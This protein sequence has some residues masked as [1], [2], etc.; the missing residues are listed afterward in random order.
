MPYPEVKAKADERSKSGIFSVPE[1]PLRNPSFIGVAMKRILLPVLILWAVSMTLPSLATA[2]S[3]KKGVDLFNEAKALNAKA[4]SKEDREKAL[5]KF[6]EALEIFKKDNSKKDQANTINWMASVY[7]A[8]GQ[9]Q[10]AVEVYRKELDIRKSLND[11]KAEGVVLN[12]IGWMFHNLN[13]EQ[14]A[15]ENL[16]KS[17]EM[18]RKA[19]NSPM[20]G[21]TLN[22]IG[23]VYYK[24][25]QYQKA[26]DVWA[27][28]LDVKKKLNDGPGQGLVLHNMATAYDNMSD[29]LKGVEYYEKSLELYKKANDTKGAGG[30]LS[31]IAYDYERLGDH[32]KCV[33]YGEKA[34]TIQ[35]MIKDVNGEAVA[36][37]RIGLGY[38]GL[39]QYSKA[40]ECYEKSLELHRKAG[41]SKSEGIVLDNMGRAYVALGDEQKAL[42]HYKNALEIW[43]R[44]HDVQWEAGTLTRMGFVYDKLGELQNALDQYERAM[45]IRKKSGDRLGEANLVYNMGASYF[46]AAQF[47]K[48]L[49]YFDKAL[50]IYGALG[51]PKGE[52]NT[53][54]YISLTCRELSQYQKAQEAGERALEIARRIENPDMQAT[55]LLRVGDTYLCTGRS[56]K[57]LEYYT[58]ALNLPG[59]KSNYVGGL[60]H[61]MGLAY[62]SRGEYQ[63]AL[64][65]YEKALADEVRVKNLREQGNTLNC[66]GAA[67]YQLGQYRKALESYEKGLA[68][69]RKTGH[70]RAEANSL[71]RIGSFYQSWGDRQKALEY[72]QNAGA[73]YR[74]IG[75]VSGEAGSFFDIGRVHSGLNEY[76]EAI[77]NYQ[78][79]MEMRE[80]IGIPTGASKTLMAAVYMEKRQLDKAEEL[81]KD[82]NFGDQD[83]SGAP[84]ANWALGKL[85]LLKGDFSESELY[86]TKLLNQ[87]EKRRNKPLRVTGYTGIGKVCEAREDYEK[88]EEY[89][90]RAMKLTEEMRAELLPSERRNFFDV[91]SNGFY[92]SEPANGLTRVKMKL[93]KAGGSID[94]SEVTRAR[95]F[96]DNIA[97]RSEA[98]YS[99]VPKDIL[100]REEVLD[101]KVAALKKQLSKID[102][103]AQPGYY[104]TLSKEV[105]DA[106][107]DLNGF[108]EMLW[109]KYVAYASV[110]Y[111]RPVTLKESS[112]KPEEHVIIFDVSDEG[113][114]IKLI[115]GKEIA[116]VYYKKWNM[117]DLEKDVNRFRRPFEENKLKEFD[118]ELGKL[119]Y[120]KLL[121]RV[122]AEVP[123]GAPL[124][125]IPDKILAVLPF[126]ALVV[127]GKPSWTGEGPQAYPEGIKYL[128]DL[129][130]ISYYQSITALSLTRTLGAKEK[131]AAKTLVIADPVFG[132]DDPRLKAASAEERKKIVAGLPD[133]LM[134]IKGQTGLSFKR[135]LLTTDLAESIKK[136]N[137]DKTDLFTGIGA[138]KSI[139]FDKPLTDYGSIVFATHGYFGKDMPGIQEPVLAMTLVG[140]PKD[141]DGFLRMT[142][143]MGM[144]LNANVIALTACQTGVGN[145]LSGEGVMSM[146]RA[147][148][149]AGA[150]SILMSLWSVSESGSVMLVEKFFEHLKE[151]KTK[152]QALNLAREDVRKAG[153][154]HPFYWAAFILVGEAD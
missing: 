121:S 80:Q 34:L 49:E 118:P 100:M 30:A 40:L 60:L 51:N 56:N 99:G 122:L 127:S 17:L 59:K 72:Y 23:L 131:T 92:R 26:L 6:Q 103:D 108:V 45:Q 9:Y 29:F 128:G 141:E 82:L 36:L 42:D 142:E 33:E 129:H 55:A 1:S 111:P 113:V 102:K 116:E 47:E 69:N 126:E 96:S 2:D 146:G 43:T 112:L 117:D 86:Y 90:D 53:L 140:Q 4:Q 105:A 133:A 11:T 28:A 93:N 151:G 115:K 85:Y 107:A 7:A 54:V 31:D 109:G 130:P 134:S 8:L 68:I 95:A 12:H 154:N 19:G 22:N 27:K 152:L 24:S 62:D 147:F 101:T 89:Y 50:A 76:D 39:E 94:S 15:L 143:V 98:G 3:V 37:N 135:L 46:K 65:C 66:I 75:N 87:G 114:G 10:K 148:Q 16:E 41:N 14:K 132:L 81:L 74:K 20:E 79:A 153:Y 57:A 32:K 91:K 21:A 136:L 35:R 5:A 83:D 145:N 124:I 125:I 63:K 67:Y 139:L 104:E 61:E 78:K 73:I 119:L 137:P 120:L 77:Q 13:Q 110:K 70:L 144:K 52:G 149:Y 58:E 84:M 71:G 123:D 97:Q 18:S 25:Q 64:E 106:E 44:T 38:H 88:A 138:Q 48:G 150:K